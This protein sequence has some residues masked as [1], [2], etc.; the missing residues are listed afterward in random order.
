MLEH[1]VLQD[2]DA[3]REV[4]GFFPNRHLGNFERLSGGYTSDV[5]RGELDGQVVIIKHARG[6]EI[7]HPSYRVSEETRMPTEIEALNRLSPIFPAEVPQILE[8]DPEHSIAVMTDVGQNATLGLPYLLSGRAEPA[9]GTALGNFLARLKQATDDWEPFA[10]VESAEEQIRIRG[11]ETDAALPEW[12]KKL[13]EYYLGQQKFLWVDGH[14]KNV[15]F[16]DQSPLVRAID[17]DCSHFADSDYMLPNFL[18]QLPVF[19]AMG[20]IS[21]DDAINF[22]KATVLAY[23]KVSPIDS[24]TE[25]KM[26]FYAATQ[27]IQRQDGKWLFDVCGGNDEESLKRKAFLFYFGRKAVSI[28]TFNE[29]LEAFEADLAKWIEQTLS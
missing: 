26:V 18:G 19:A 17:W 15:F 13:R 14:P 28:T 23:D 11:Q 7:F 2:L 25:R 3:A 12:G 10:T 8:Y 22:T 6:R 21:I 27:I 9:H 24:E 16:G 1:D 29:F 5:F 4:S 20:H